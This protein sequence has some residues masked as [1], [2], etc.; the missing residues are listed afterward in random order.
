[1]NP[2]QPL[3]QGKNV[4]LNQRPGNVPDVRGGVMSWFRPMILSYVRK[5][6]VNLVLVETCC[7]VQTSGFITPKGRPLDIKSTGQRRW[8][9]K[10]LFTLPVVVL[11]PDDIVTVVNLVKGNI[12]YRVMNIQDWSEAGY[13]AYDL[14]EDYS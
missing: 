12:S 14:L 5:E 3:Q 1:M 9:A 2:V 10:T 13:V 11:S 8:D 7:E 4:L 6:T